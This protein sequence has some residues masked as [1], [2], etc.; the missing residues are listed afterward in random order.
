M[1]DTIYTDDP[2]DTLNLTVFF[3]YLDQ[4]EQTRAE[5]QIWPTPPWF[6]RL[7]FY[8]GAAIPIHLRIMCAYS[9]AEQL[10]YYGPQA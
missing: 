7:K 4:G 2:S 5:G 8:G 3:Q 6:C 1:T 10:Q 9:L